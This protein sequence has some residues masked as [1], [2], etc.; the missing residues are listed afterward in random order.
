MIRDT[1]EIQCDRCGRHWKIQR[2]IIYRTSGMVPSSIEEL[3]QCGWMFER[4]DEYKLK[5]V[6]CPNCVKRREEIFRLNNLPGA[7][8][9]RNIS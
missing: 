4:D 8:D 5:A 2:M 1:V 3:N 6:Y 7:I 9:Q